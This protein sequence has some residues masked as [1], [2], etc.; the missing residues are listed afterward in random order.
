MGEQLNFTVKVQSESG[1]YKKSIS[2]PPYPP[3]V[4]SSF[5]SFASFSTSVMSSLSTATYYQT[6]FITDAKFKL[7]FIVPVV[8]IVL[9]IFLYLTQPVVRIG[10]SD[11]LERLMLRLSPLAFVLFLV[12]M[13][14]LYTRIVLVLF[15]L[16]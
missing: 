6:N 16:V 5:I 11:I 13:G 12:F 1:D 15:T 9:L 10:S 3:Q 2:S 8:L 7:G 14:M 4:W